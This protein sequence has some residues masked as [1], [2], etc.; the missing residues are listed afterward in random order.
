M[1]E[2]GTPPSTADSLLQLCALHFAAHFR[3]AYKRF[4]HQR[5]VRRFFGF[6]L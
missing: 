4:S 3:V 6:T 2:G 1:K 5:M